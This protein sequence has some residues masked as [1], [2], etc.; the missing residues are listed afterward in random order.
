MADLW[1]TN[2]FC[3]C[4]SNFLSFSILVAPHALDAGYTIKII[5]S[6]KIASIAYSTC[7]LLHGWT[8]GTINGLLLFWS[9]GGFKHIRMDS[10]SRLLAPRLDRYWLLVTPSVHLHSKPCMHHLFQYTQYQSRSY[11]CSIP[12]EV[13]RQI[14]FGINCIILLGRLQILKADRN[15]S[16]QHICPSRVVT[17]K[18]IRQLH[19]IPIV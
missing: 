13:A 8:V 6:I 14:I 3:C 1:S 12:F 2:C 11:P 4:F 18:K 10:A 17:H 19:D 7:K 9:Q 15:T 5:F 16:F